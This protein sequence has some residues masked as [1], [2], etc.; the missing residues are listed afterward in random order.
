MRSALALLA[1]ASL[2]CG[3]GRSKMLVPPAARPDA[4][5]SPQPDSALLPDAVLA[6]TRPRPPDGPRGADVLPPQSDVRPPADGPPFVIPDAAP[7]RRP[8]DPPS[9]GLPPPPPDGPPLVRPD[10]PPDG[11]PV[12]GPDAR[13]DGPPPVAPEVRPD[14]PPFTVPEVGPD[15]PPLITPD[16][17]PDV[18][19]PPPDVQPD[20]RRPRPDTR[21]PQECAAGAACTTDCTATCSA[22]GTMTCTCVDGV[23]VCGE[24]ELPPITISPEPCPDNPSRTEC[25]TSGLACIVFA[26]DGTIGGA[27]MCVARGG[28][29]ALRWSCVLR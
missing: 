23:L 26:D 11:P 12:I 29:G 22:I 9:D 24:C 5:T 4:A 1:L 28:S 25:S 18:L 7:D 16:V 10:A 19:P 27:C 6:D 14:G 3:M 15:G 20:G 21:P 17:P 13:F 2:G 8:A